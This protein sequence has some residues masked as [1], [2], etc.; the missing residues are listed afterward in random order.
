[1]FLISLGEKLIQDVETRCGGTLCDPSIKRLRREDCE[2]S[3]SLR[4]IMR[5]HLKTNKL[6]TFYV[7]LGEGGIP[8]SHF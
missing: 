2:F 1:M 4:Y 3:S 8:D 5:S 6:E 7:L